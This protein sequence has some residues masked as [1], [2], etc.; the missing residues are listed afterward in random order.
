MVE[1]V[2]LV[3]VDMV[4]LAHHQVSQEDLVVML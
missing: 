3:V 1:M 4:V 2:D